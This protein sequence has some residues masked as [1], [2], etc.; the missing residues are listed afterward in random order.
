[1]PVQRRVIEVKSDWTGSSPPWTG[2]LSKA[3]GVDLGDVHLVSHGDARV[4][5][6]A[7]LR[8]GLTLVERGES[9]RTRP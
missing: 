9:S 3:M 5:A 4:L 1:M 8:V 6:A 2:R 7:A